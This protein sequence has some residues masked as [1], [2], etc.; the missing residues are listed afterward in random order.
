MALLKGKTALITGAASGQ[1]A[2]EARKLAAEG[3]RVVVADVDDTRGAEVAAGIGAEHCVYERLD[4]SSAEDWSR[5]VA[6]T[7]KRF[8]S[9][10]ILVNN[11]AVFR[12]ASLEQTDDATFD[13][14]YR[15]NQRGAFYGMRAV[16]PQMHKQGGGCIL[17]IGSTSG[18]RAVPNMWAYGSSKWAIRGMTRHAAVELAPKNIRVNCVFP[19]TIDTPMLGALPA[20]AKAGLAT[21]VPIGRLG[22][23]EEIA[24]AVCFLASD[25]ARYITGAE[26]AVDGAMGA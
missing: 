24:E 21:M 18:L 3:A 17:N 9:L 23:P 26:I 8:G 20:E 6:A 5:V 4:V 19:G 2:A 16:L 14:I 7:V 13:L 11:A 25:A 1:G 12:L 22:T 15:V 10:D